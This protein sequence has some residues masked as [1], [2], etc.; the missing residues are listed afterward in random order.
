VEV[1]IGG[2]SSLPQDMGRSGYP[3]ASVSLLRSGPRPIATL[4]EESVT[5]GSDVWLASQHLLGG[6]LSVMPG[7]PRRV[8]VSHTSELRRLPEGRSFMLAAEQ[9]VA[10]AGDA[11][12]DMAYV[13][14]RDEAPAQVCRQAVAK[15]DVYVAI[16]GFCYGSPVRDRPELSYTE[17]EFE[18]ASEGGKP[19]L[20]FL[21]DDHAQGPKDLFVDREYG[22]RQEAFRTRLNESGLTTATVSTPDQLE[23]ALFQALVELPRGRSGPMSAGQAWNVPVRN[24][25]FIGREQLLKNLRSTLYT[26]L[27]TVV[28]A[29]HGMGGIGK[30]AL[31]I[32]YA[33]RHLSDYDIVW[34]VPAEEPT[35]IPGRLT[36]LAQALGLAEQTETAAVA[37][38][39][40]LRALQDR[41]R[42]LLIYDNAE[43]PGALAKY[44]PGSGGHILI[45]TRN[46]NWHE[47]AAPLS[48]DVFDRHES[49]ALLRQRVPRLSER[50]AGR[51]AE[52][53]KDLPLAVTQ[54]AT[55]LAESGCA[56]EE[57]LTS[58]SSRA[59]EVLAQ[60]APMTYPASL[61]ASWELAFDR[62]AVDEPAALDLLTLA[63]QLAPEPIPFTLF[64]AHCDRLPEPLATAAGDP[65]AFARLTRL[66]RQR[67]LVRIDADH[68]QL[69]R[70]VQAILR[71]RMDGTTDTNEI[72]RTVLGLLCRATPADPR[73]NPATWPAWQQLLPHIFATT[74]PGRDLDPN[75]QDVAWLL[76]GAATYLHARGEP[77]T[78]L[79]LVERA[80]QLYRQALGDDDPN[81]MSS[82]NNLAFVLRALGQYKRAR[83]L[84]KDNLVRFRRLL[85]DDDPNTMSSANNLAFDLRALGKHGRARQLHEDNLVRFRRLLGDDH[86]RTLASANNL[87]VVLRDLGEYEQACQLD[88]DTLTRHRRVLGDDHPTTLYSAGNLAASLAMLGEYEQAC[89]LDKDTLTRCRRVLGDDHPNTLTSANNLAHNLS[90][91]GEYERALQIFQDTLTRRR[92]VL[93]DD[94]P[95]TLCSANNLTRRLRRLGKHG[96]A[97]E[98]EKWIKS[99][100][101]P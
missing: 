29:V 34:W 90:A 65:L 85:G 63:A 94:H 84:D 56:V 92:R 23:T 2:L 52:T 97:N 83:Q 62:L 31:A 68:L 4:T 14:A 78:A 88:K 55:F 61:T 93:G 51:I 21:L 7:S 60:G 42:W 35:L 10:R 6:M 15:A 11:V 91:L 43:D 72:G 16:V 22:E 48:V 49:V 73:R 57:Y 101:R 12:G 25:T 45:T 26:G 36:E 96:Q 30:T 24:P 27:S 59:A 76:D 40:L 82:A 86:P 99:Q 17:L 8:F 69:H 46:P 98:L 1:I 58:L 28:Q 66:L 53:L 100:Y 95:D 38:S 87:A 18:S 5:P 32:E 44:L 71:A 64:T 41:A 9:A 79:P 74:E 81:T 67:A 47:L 54:A 3:V 20:V 39:R 89:Q 75:R 77:R 80:F 33:H 37:V 50:D 70:L 13:G 19:R